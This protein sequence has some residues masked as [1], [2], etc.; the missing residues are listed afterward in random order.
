M[1]LILLVLIM[2]ICTGCDKHFKKLHGLSL[3]RN[4]CPGGRSGP[5]FEQALSDSRSFRKQNVGLKFREWQ[6]E[7][8]PPPPDPQKFGEDSVRNFKY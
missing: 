7:K 4:K 6:E 2:V 8:Q 5:I 3:H 1:K